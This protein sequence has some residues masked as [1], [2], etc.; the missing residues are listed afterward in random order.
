M[1]NTSLFVVNNICY[2]I[3]F[4]LLLWE[5]PSGLSYYKAWDFPLVLASFCLIDVKNACDSLQ[6]SQSLICR[7]VS[8]SVRTHHA[9]YM[10]WN[11]QSLIPRKKNLVTENNEMRKKIAFQCFNSLPKLNVVILF[12]YNSDI[13]YKLHVPFSDWITFIYLVSLIGIA[14]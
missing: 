8:M 11:P 1:A 7:V 2:F 10:T 12:T 13:H 14:H 3:Y 9:F 4:I 5:N 6:G